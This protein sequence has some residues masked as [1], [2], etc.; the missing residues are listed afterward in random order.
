[1]KRIKSDGNFLH[2]SNASI[3]GSGRCHNEPLSESQP[4][5]QSG[6]QGLNLESDSVHENEVSSGYE[7]GVSHLRSVY[8]RLGFYLHLSSLQLP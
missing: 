7:S 5:V 1:M 4:D 8:A 6:L 2:E 3:S